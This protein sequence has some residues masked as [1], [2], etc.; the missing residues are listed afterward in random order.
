MRSHRLTP[1]KVKIAT[2]LAAAYLIGLPSKDAEATITTI[3]SPFT[4]MNSETFEGFA[5]GFVT[6]PESILG[7]TASL[8]STKS[9]YVYQGDF[10]IGIPSVIAQTSDG[11]RGMAVNGSNTT[12]TIAFAAP[13][14]DFGGYFGSGSPSDG[15]T[16]LFQDAGNAIIGGQN[17]PYTRNGSF[18][19]D[20]GLDWHGFHSSLPISSVEL[21]GDFVVFDGL[22]TNVI[23]EPT[24]LVLTGLGISFIALRRRR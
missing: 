17:I 12:T 22:Q 21:I 3:A 13:I 1:F 10:G 7:G 19:G 20:G 16:I 5:N 11:V 24:T 8:S 4:G 2:L 9:L 23:P 14:I 18:G 6:Q 15:L